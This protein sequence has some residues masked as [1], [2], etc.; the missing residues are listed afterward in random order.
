MNS[1]LPDEVMRRLLLLFECLL[2]LTE[3][4][5]D[6]QSLVV[7][8]ITATTLGTWCFLVKAM[9]YGVVGMWPS[10]AE[11]QLTS[12]CPLLKSF[13]MHTSRVQPS[14]S[15]DRWTGGASEASTS[16]STP[17][18]S[19]GAQIKKKKKKSKTEVSCVRIF[20]VMNYSHCWALITHICFI[21]KVVICLY[22]LHVFLNLM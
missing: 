17:P 8:V 20:A 13:T 14:L 4:L 3:Q 7:T 2:R 18:D 5:Y 6:G 1:S 15:P 21:I 16:P 9:L 22:V 10:D 12:K 11:L 19:G